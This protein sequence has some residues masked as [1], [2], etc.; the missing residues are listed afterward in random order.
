M[1][2]FKKILLCTDLSP[3]ADAAA[4][5]A[6]E[7]ARRYGGQIQ[8]FHVFED[9]VFYPLPITEAPVAVDLS[10]FIKGSH[11]DRLKVL[12]KK[13]EALA[14]DSGVT[15]VPVVLR[16]HPVQETIKYAKSEQ[17]DCIVIATHGRTGATHLF[18]GS[19]AERIVRESPCPVLSV[20]PK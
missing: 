15:V 17:I 18:F 1:I 13:A 6:V 8:L 16:G 10:D 5:Y 19:V 7:L 9:L 12:G 11:A 4:P 3:N 20:R 14:K 2:S